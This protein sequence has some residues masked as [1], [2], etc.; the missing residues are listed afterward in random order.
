M[1][2]PCRNT[3]SYVLTF[4]IIKNK[5]DFLNLKRYLIKELSSCH[6]A[7]TAECR[8]CCITQNVMQK[9]TISI[10]LRCPPPALLGLKALN[11]N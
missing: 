1:P 10:S 2:A 6:Q 5:N 8:R 4:P 11:I 9:N 7:Q 3:F